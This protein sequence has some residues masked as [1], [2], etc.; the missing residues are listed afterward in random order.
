MTRVTLKSLV[1]ALAVGA[2]APAMAAMTPQEEAAFRQHCTGDYMRLCS[3]YDP[4]S[5]AVE[6]CFKERQKDL[7]PR[8]QATIASYSKTNPKG[9]R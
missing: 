3:Q 6:Q 2:T 4:D 1:L 8:C 5:P 7:S 9:R